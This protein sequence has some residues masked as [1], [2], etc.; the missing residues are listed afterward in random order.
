MCAWPTAIDHRVDTVVER[1]ALIPKYI[2]VYSLQQVLRSTDIVIVMSMLMLPL[3]VCL[4]REDYGVVAHRQSAISKADTD[5]IIVMAG[6]L[7]V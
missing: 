3:L 2:E 5:K 7:L 4:V 1:R 6:G